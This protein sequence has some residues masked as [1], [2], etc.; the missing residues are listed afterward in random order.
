M[1][2]K[3]GEVLGTYK[4]EIYARGWTVKGVKEDLDD[5]PQCRSLHLELLVSKREDGKW[6]A[7]DS[8]H[9]RPMELIN[10]PENTQFSHNCIFDNRDV[11]AITDIP[12][13]SEFLVNYGKDYWT[14]CYIKHDLRPSR[15]SRNIPR[16]KGLMK[17]GDGSVV[18]FRRK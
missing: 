16:G 12:S 3:K 5:A 10:S 18:V 2:I 14:G 9:C 11:K 13:G 17:K 6:E 1:D 8:S 4:G 7:H 15:P